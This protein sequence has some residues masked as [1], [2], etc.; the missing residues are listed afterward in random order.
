MVSFLSYKLKSNISLVLLLNKRIF[1]SNSFK[2]NSVPYTTISRKSFHKSVDKY[3]DKEI[4]E[5][6]YGKVQ[7]SYDFTDEDYTFYSN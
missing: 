6:A 5:V 4:G 2:I 7:Y 1:F 3:V